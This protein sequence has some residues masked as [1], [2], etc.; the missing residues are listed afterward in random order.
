M[1]GSA[2]LLPKLPNCYVRVHNLRESI[3][4]YTMQVM[5]GVNRAG[6]VTVPVGV[7]LARAAQQGCIV[8]DLSGAT[9]RQLA[10]DRRAQSLDG[11]GI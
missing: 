4:S 9:L 3:R 10:R 2:A 6:G 1:L 5:V 11:S 7:D 8:Q